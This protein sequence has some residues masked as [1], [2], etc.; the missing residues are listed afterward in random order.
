MN[1]LSR[2]LGSFSALRGA[3]PAVA[4]A[5]VTA[6]TLAACGGSGG[7]GISSTGTGTNPCASQNGPGP[8]GWPGNATQGYLPP[9]EPDVDCD[10][11]VRIGILSP[12]DTHDHGYYESF[13]DAAKQYATANG[14][15][16]IVVDKINPADAANQA[17]NMCRQHVDMVAIAASE[18][19]DAI[20]VSSEAVCK[21]AVWYVG[22]GQGVTQTKYFVQSQDDASETLYVAGYAAGLLMQAKGATKAGFLTGPAY[23]FAK[24]AAKAFAVGI[25]VVVPNAQV[26]AT[27][28]G[29]FNDSAKAVEAANAM[30]SQGVGLIYPYLGGATDAVETLLNQHNIPGLTPG[31]NRCGEGTPSYAMSVIFSPGD[32]FAAALQDFKAGTL[33]VGVARVFHVGKDPVPTVKI[34]KPTGDEQQRVDS[35]IQQIGQG[36]IKPDDL[37]AAAPN[38]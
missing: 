33:R 15:D 12:G 30:I 21:G 16:V 1:G 26:V 23:D 8:W 4:A 13:V 6:L 29:D 25:K 10:G 27:Y 24:L 20:P 19:K 14:W 11:T 28:T 7:S 17:R 18:L 38:I 5:A 37:V 31:T 36:V 32:Y 34:C 3:R 2:F 35:V 9:H 22:A